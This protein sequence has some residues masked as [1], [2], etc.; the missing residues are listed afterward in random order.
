MGSASVLK[1]LTCHGMHQLEPS[2]KYLHSLWGNLSSVSTN[3]L[4]FWKARMYFQQS[5]QSNL[6]FQQWLIPLRN[7]EALPHQLKSTH[8][9]QSQKTHLLLFSVGNEHPCRNF[10]CSLFEMNI[11]VVNI[12]CELNKIPGN[13][14]PLMHSICFPRRNTPPIKVII[15]APTVYLLIENFPYNIV[16]VSETVSIRVLTFHSQ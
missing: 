14:V 1:W 9:T 16:S 7:F 4:I 12:Y 5:S 3:V 13:K 6:L 15:L 2:Q 11:H 8:H 10:F